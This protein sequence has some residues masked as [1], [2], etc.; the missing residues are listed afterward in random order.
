MRAVASRLPWCLG[1]RQTLE[2]ELR[3][4]GVRELTLEPR[5]V[6][7]DRGQDL[8]LGRAGPHR[9]L[10]R[11]TG[12]EADAVPAHA[13][14]AAYVQLDQATT[15]LDE[16]HG[17]TVGVAADGNV[18]DTTAHR[19]SHSL[20]GASAPLAAAVTLS[21]HRRHSSHPCLTPDVSGPA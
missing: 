7:L 19:S 21:L 20:R 1:Q 14:R 8:G 13:R 18:R 3:L 4:R 10:G 9:E 6:V 12:A 17:A 15:H 11:L 16:A 2:P 5:G